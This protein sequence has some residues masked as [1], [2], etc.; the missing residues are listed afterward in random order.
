[1]SKEERRGHD[2]PEHKACTPAE[3]HRALADAVHELSGVSW[4]E[5]IELSPHAL[6]AIFYNPSFEHY[7]SNDEQVARK[8]REH[9][10]QVVLRHR[11]A[12]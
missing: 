10:R 5:L 7:M 12:L 8:R 4:M 2:L 6:G 1:M 3:K 11:I 9:N